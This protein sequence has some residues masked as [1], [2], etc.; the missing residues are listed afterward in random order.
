MLPNIVLKPAAVKFISGIA[1]FCGLPAGAGYRLA[2]AP[3]G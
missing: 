2:V 1:R 3:G